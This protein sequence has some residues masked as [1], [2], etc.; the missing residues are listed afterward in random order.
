MFSKYN[1][2]LI[3]IYK[4]VQ[5]LPYIFDMFYDLIHHDASYRLFFIISWDDD[6]VT[7]I[8]SKIN[9][10]DLDVIRYVYIWPDKSGLWSAYHQWFDHIRNYFDL[11]KIDTIITMD[12]DWSHDMSYIQMM[13]KY[14][15][16]WYDFVV[17]SRYSWKWYRYEDKLNYIDPKSR[18]SWLW[19]FIFY[20]ISRNKIFDK[21]SGFRMFKSA[22]IHIFD[23]WYPNNFTY[24][25]Y[26][27]FLLAKK[28][29]YNTYELPIV[30][31]KRMYWSSKF[32][33]LLA[34]KN[35]TYIIHRLV[36]DRLLPW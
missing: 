28:C 9:K 19:N 6:S 11:N 5:N 3:P 10:Y 8:K 15:A 35:Y 17:W 30:F 2:I 13:H 33:F 23:N 34:I 4:E 27:N 1:L 20:I 26:T 18:L 31:K 14:I 12:G 16:L 22:Y 7:Y 24:N 32:N 36:K 29:N 21:T 25:F